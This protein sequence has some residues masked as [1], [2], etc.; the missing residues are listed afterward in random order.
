MVAL[1]A[2]LFAA[3][4]ADIASP[5]AVAALLAAFD[6][7]FAA[8]VEFSA[9]L[10]A[11]DTASCAAS[12]AFSAISAEFLTEARASTRALNSSELS[13]A[14]SSNALASIF[15]KKFCEDNNASPS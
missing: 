8:A 10:S 9:A 3:F 1:V 6:A 14:F 5:V 7:A 12:A 15:I 11:V 4:V 2:A 13:G